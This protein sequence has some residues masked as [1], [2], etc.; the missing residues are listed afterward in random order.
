MVASTAPWPV[1]PPSGELDLPCEDGEPMDTPRHSQQM[2]LLITSLELA[3]RDRDD[4]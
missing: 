2:N 1:P 4:Y 3:W